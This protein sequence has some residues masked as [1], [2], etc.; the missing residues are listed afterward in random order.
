MRNP[1][2]HETAP[3]RKQVFNNALQLE[4]E[5]IELGSSLQAVDLQIT[6]SEQSNR[7]A[8]DVYL[9]G[10]DET[11]KNQVSSMEKTLENFYGTL[12]W[13]ETSTADLAF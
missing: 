7:K 1:D 9:Y 12:K 11:K 8:A 5:I 3:N 2:M 13:I 6:Q 4:G 10:I